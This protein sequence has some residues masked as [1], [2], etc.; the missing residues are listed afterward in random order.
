LEVQKAKEQLY[1][2]KIKIESSMDGK[3][4]NIAEVRHQLKATKEHCDDK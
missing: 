2:D 1:L 3:D 4:N